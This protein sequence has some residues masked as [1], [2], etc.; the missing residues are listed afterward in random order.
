MAE[1][2]KNQNGQNQQSSNAFVKK[3]RRRRRPKKNKPLFES[4]GITQQTGSGDVQAVSPASKAHTAPIVGNKRK[5]RRRP[6]KR[7]DLN[8]VQEAVAPV[9]DGSSAAVDLPQEEPELVVEPYSPPKVEEETYDDIFNDNSEDSGDSEDLEEEK[10]EDSGLNIEPEPEPEPEKPSGGWA[11]LKEAIKKDHEETRKKIEQAPTEDAQVGEIVTPVFE[12]VKPDLSEDE[13][14]KKEVIQIIVRYVLGGCAVIA[15]ISAIFFFRLPQRVFE[16]ITGL[17]EGESGQIESVESVESAEESGEVSD[18]TKELESTFV[19]GENKVTSRDKFGESIETALITGEESPI[20]QGVPD[21]IKALYVAGIEASDSSYTDRIGV[22]MGVLTKLQNAFATDIHQMLDNSNNR[23]SALNLHLSELKSVYQEAVD[24]RI[25][26]NEEKDRLKVQF[27][28]VT[29]QKEKF[30][31]DFFVALDKLE[32][33]K[34]NDLLNLFIESSKRQIE[35]KAHYNALNKASGLFDIAL[36]NMEAR[37]KDIEFNKLALIQ[38][39]KV[40]DIKGSNLDLVIQE[41]ELM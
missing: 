25:I 4:P 21:P 9:G 22:Y 31:K 20:Y 11:D 23:E 17:F 16:G 29:T 32:A 38:G 6:K 36:K 35:L 30:E 40:V 27:N 26:V 10:V 41:S 13:L 3:K 12:G 8:P 33:N 1:E 2:D 34:S 37:I 15:I 24:T 28:E 19:A 7:P 39:V 14:E 18:K 5:R